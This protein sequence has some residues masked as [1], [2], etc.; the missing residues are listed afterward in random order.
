MTKHSKIAV[1]ASAGAL[2]LA[3]CTSETGDSTADE[4]SGADTGSSIPEGML[5]TWDYVGGTCEPAS[6]LR[7]EIAPGQLVFY[8]AVGEVLS[9][10]RNGDDVTLSLAMEGEGD[11][12]QDSLTFRMVEGGDLLESDIP[13]PSGEGLLRRKRCEG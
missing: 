8:E 4:A 3:A 9:V 7:L 12:W 2:L 10:S 11:T 1:L 6:D 13:S 5:G